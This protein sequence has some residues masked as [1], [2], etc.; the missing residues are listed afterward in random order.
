MSRIGILALQGA[1]A[2]H[3][4]MLTRLGVETVEVRTPEHLQGIDGLIIPGGESTSI[5][6]LIRSAGLFDALST[7]IQHFPTWGTCAGAILLARHIEGAEP[8]LAV[9]DI[10]V[11]RNGFGRQRDSF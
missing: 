1:F 11:R 8:H 10:T 5:S 6:R 3:R 7:F 9:M 4:Q 2:E